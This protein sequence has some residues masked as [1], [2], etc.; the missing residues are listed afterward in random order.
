MLIV[1]IWLTLMGLCVM[2][3]YRSGRLRHLLPPTSFGKGAVLFLLVLWTGQFGLAMH[4]FMDQ[5]RSDQ[6]L[7][8][9]SYWLL[10]VWTTLFLLA[11]AARA[12]ETDPVLAAARGAA[13]PRWRVGRGI[14]IGAASAPLLVCLFAWIATAVQDGPDGRARWRF[15]PR[16]YWRDPGPRS[17]VSVEGRFQKR[18]RR[19]ATPP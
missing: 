6:I 18:G 8:E 7:V 4:R 12:P 2:W 16:A 5:S 14:W 9:V 13:D 1:G 11:L 19:P 3:L 15:G 10:T 17:E